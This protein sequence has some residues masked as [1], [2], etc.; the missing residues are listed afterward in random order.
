MLSSKWMGSL[1]LMMTGKLTIV[2]AMAL[3]FVQLRCVAWCA[4][5][6]ADL[7]QLSEAGSHNIP[8]CHRHQSD[9]SKSS[10]ISPCTHG[11]VIAS[12]ASFSTTQAPVVA[13]LVAILSAQPEANPTVLIS[14]D[15]SAV[16]ITSPPG[17]GGPSSL[18]LRI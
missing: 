18:V 17:S 3:V 9:S 12:A 8:P 4:T 5:S 14:G 2:L 6:A 11:V 7:T 10:P 15:E 16:L 13:P 1:N